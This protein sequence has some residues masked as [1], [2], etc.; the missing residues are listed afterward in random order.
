MLNVDSEVGKRKVMKK[1]RR[2][3]EL[4]RQR[5]ASLISADGGV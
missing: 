5:K 2:N 3:K 1:G 4:G